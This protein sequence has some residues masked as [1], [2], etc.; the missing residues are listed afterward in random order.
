MLYSMA[1]RFMSAMVQKLSSLLSVM[2]SVFSLPADA[3]NGQLSVT[4]QGN[5]VNQIIQ[6]GNF[7]SGTTGWIAN[8]ASH[9]VTNN[10]LSNTC[11]GS[12]NTPNEAQ[13]TNIPYYTNQKVYVRATVRVTS[14]L[15]SLIR[16]KIRGSTSGTSL[17]V[18]QQ[19]APT[20]NQWYVLSAVATM[21]VD[22]VGNV[23]IYAFHEYADVATANGK[24][25]EVKEVVL[26]D[27][28]SHGLDALTQA[29]C[30][31]RFPNW[32][33]SGTKSTFKEGGRVLSKDGTNIINNGNFANG[34]TSWASARSNSTTS[35]NT[36]INTGSGSN[37]TPYVT[38]AIQFLAGHKYYFRAK[39][40][41]TNSVCTQVGFELQGTT[42]YK[43]NPVINT[44]YTLSEVK[45]FASSNT[46]LFLAQYYVD[47]ATASGKVMEIQDVTIIDMGTDSSNGLYNLT[48]AQMD[49]KFPTWFDSTQ[50]LSIATIP[51]S[52]NGLIS[53]GNVKDELSV[54]DGTRIIRCKPIILGVDDWI[55]DATY[56]TVY[57]FFLTT[58]IADC[59]LV[60]ND[61]KRLTI[62]NTDWKYT[63]SYTGDYEHFY[64]SSTPKLF[65]FVNKSTIDGQSG[66]DVLTKFK[67]WL[68]ANSS[69]LTY[70]LA[71]PIVS[72]V[73]ITFTEN[74]VPSTGLR[75]WGPNTTVIQEVDVPENSTLATMNYKYPVG[76]PKNEL[77]YNPNTWVE[78]IGKLS[79]TIV[80]NYISITNL[81]VP[82]AY[83]TTLLK[84]STKYGILLNIRINTRTN[85]T[86]LPANAAGTTPFAGDNTI[87]AGITGNIKSIMTTKASFATNRIVLYVPLNA[88]KIELG[89]IRVFELPAGSQIEADFTNLTADQLAIKYPF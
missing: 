4:V 19:N 31:A 3:I 60:E 23:R 76:F 11:D 89:D 50:N 27:L 37:P 18:A 17:T 30:D 20:Q 78:W 46:I 40:K 62:G 47:S 59:T 9:S 26:I 33:S 32:L 48:V 81:D 42:L 38:Q 2:V 71:T 77:V 79:S 57:R 12:S 35:N 84:T 70:Q 44:Q 82:A 67:N 54:A 65:L 55:L 87:A 21:P 7:A 24:V 6:N 88:G 16:L 68:V 13:S 52:T 69:T 43:I 66:I 53:V 61:I 85:L 8:A 49:A 74:G 51:P 14:S 36:L 72:Y 1:L 80:S 56:S 83:L 25:M 58:A 10:I 73:P 41:V 28:T 75:C 39:F 15:A 45:T 22:S 34:T 86:Y 5:T 64:V 29:Q 63:V